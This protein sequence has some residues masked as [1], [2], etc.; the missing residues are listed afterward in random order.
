MG[1]CPLNNQSFRKYLVCPEMLLRWSSQ[2]FS[3]KDFSLSVISICQYILLILLCPLKL[4][5]ILFSPMLYD[6]SRLIHPFFGYKYFNFYGVHTLYSQHESPLSS[7]CGHVFCLPDPVALQEPHSH[8]T[9]EVMCDATSWL[10]LDFI[11]TQEIISN[12]ALIVNSYYS[13]SVMNSSGTSWESRTQSFLYRL[14]EKEETVGYL[15]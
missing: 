2:L 8:L 7:L 6:S 9:C 5:V 12:S 14:K 3:S 4:S 10:L 1:K 13:Q 15:F 11:L